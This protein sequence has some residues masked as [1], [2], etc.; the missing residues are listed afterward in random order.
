MQSHDAFI[1][2]LDSSQEKINIF[3]NEN[4][5]QIKG[6][7]NPRTNSNT[8]LQN[9]ILHLLNIFMHINIKENKYQASMSVLN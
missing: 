4:I 9:L 8:S 3:F 1:K 6:R 7:H 2:M 5:L